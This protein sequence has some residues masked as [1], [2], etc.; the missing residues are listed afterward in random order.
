[1]HP[2]EQE[3]LSRSYRSPQILRQ[4]ENTSQPSSATGS[5]LNPLP[6]GGGMPGNMNGP[7]NVTQ[8]PNAGG[9][10]IRRPVPV[11]GVPPAVVA[12][13]LKQTL[14]SGFPIPSPPPSYTSAIK[15]VKYCS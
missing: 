10:G 1:M 11:V 14:E 3:I 12:A 6:P 13:A 5:P 15:E 2:G 7:V 4:L 9:P 8:Q